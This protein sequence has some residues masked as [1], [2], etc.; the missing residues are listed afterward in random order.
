MLRAFGAF[1]VVFSL[2]SLI[3]GL[4]VLSACFG[5]GALSVFAAD[6]GLVRFCK[7]TVVSLV[8]RQP[9]LQRKH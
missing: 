3:V 8:E 4:N 2:L 6:A 5:L 7:T 1:L 9:M